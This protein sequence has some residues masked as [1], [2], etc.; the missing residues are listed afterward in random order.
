M[1]VGDAFDL[2]GLT[3]ERGHRLQVR[4]EPVQQRNEPAPW[5]NSRAELP[6]IY[7]VVGQKSASISA[8]F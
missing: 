8:V 5:E 3:A 4:R 2:I 7:P 1:H 6:N